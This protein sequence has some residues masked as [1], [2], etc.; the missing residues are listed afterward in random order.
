MPLYDFSDHII[1]NH[2]FCY[3][4]KYCCNLSIFLVELL[5]HLSML[6]CIWVLCWLIFSCI[7]SQFFS[8]STLPASLSF[9]L[10]ILSSFYY[11]A[12]SLNR[13]VIIVLN[14]SMFVLKVSI[15]ILV[16]EVWVVPWGFLW[17][18]WIF[19]FTFNFIT[20][21]DGDMVHIWLQRFLYVGLCGNINISISLEWLVSWFSILNK[22]TKFKLSLS[23]WLW[24][25]YY[26]CLNCAKPILNSVDTQVKL[27]VVLCCSYCQKVHPLIPCRLCDFIVTISTNCWKQVV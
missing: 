9:S 13:V 5:L 3:Y 10:L 22:V 26:S 4:L 2:L 6:L 24:F 14:L 7:N 8:L 18:I 23:H 11:W 17:Y 15:V 16:A 19:V 27:I 20:P 1:W 25:V 21:C 12:L